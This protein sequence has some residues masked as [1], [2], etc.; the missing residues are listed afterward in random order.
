MELL[1]VVLGGAILGAI[2]RYSLP[3]RHSYG[4]VILPALGAI[5]ATVVWVGL[6]WLGLKWDGGWIWWV[7][8]LAAAGVS[9]LAALW[10]PRGRQR[11]DEHRLTELLKV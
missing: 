7:T 11:A 3:G 4:A 2:V 10:L 8:F 5:V 1:F 6:T 9:V